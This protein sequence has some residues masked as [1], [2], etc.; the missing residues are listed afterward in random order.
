MVYME[1]GGVEKSDIMGFQI[2]ETDANLLA[3]VLSD[4]ISEGKAEQAAVIARLLEDPECA[5]P[6]RWLLLGLQ[7]AHAGDLDSAE[8][9]FKKALELGGRNPRL[10]YELSKVLALK[11]EDHQAV[12][13]A[14]KT[15][16]AA[17][18]VAIGY[19]YLARL[20]AAK[21]RID[22]ARGVL[23]KVMDSE[24]FS[25]AT[26][27][28]AGKKLGVI[29]MNARRY[30]EAVPYLQKAALTEEKDADL[31]MNLAHCYSRAGNLESAL[32]AFRKAVAIDPSPDNLYGLGDCLLA[33]DRNKDAIA[34]LEK[35]VRL[36]PHHIMANYDLGLAYYR[37]NRYE[38]GVAVSKRALSDDPEIEHQRSNPGL[39]ATTNLGLCLMEIGRGEEALK[40]FDKNIGLIVPSFFNK[41]VTLWQLDRLK[42]AAVWFRRVLEI[43]PNDTSALNQLGQVLDADGKFPEAVSCLKKAI[44]IDPEYALGYY[45]LGVILSRKKDGREEAMRCFKKALSLPLREPFS[46]YAI[47]SIACLHALAGRKKEAFDSLER[48]LERGYPNRKYID[49]DKDLNGIRRDARFTEMMKK[50]FGK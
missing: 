36:Q 39:G 14:E 29:F 31:W 15:V 48:A 13:W 8:T 6:E 3:S 23:R 50:Y 20:H 32:E 49:E 27:D 40:C 26:K 5:D 12:V 43:N 34:I 41:G 47:Y 10:Y 33:L 45:D 7:A 19:F 30:M 1:L 11:G 25:E 21:E 42:E 38:E 2:K 18:D 24:D 35:A 37:E 16:E 28:E 44:E 9:R 17:P 22:E 4:L 46:A